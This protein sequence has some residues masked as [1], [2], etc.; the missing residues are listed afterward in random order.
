[1]LRDDL[2]LHVSRMSVGSLLARLCRLLEAITEL[3]HDL[4]D[5]TRDVRPGGE[6]EL[7]EIEMKVAE[8]AAVTL[9]DTACA[10]TAAAAVMVMASDGNRTA[11][12]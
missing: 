4:L 9:V 7:L 11:E 5:L 12:S 2:R 10:G 6:V 8:D 3:V 1:M